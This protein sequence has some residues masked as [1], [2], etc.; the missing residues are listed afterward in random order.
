MTS[1][2]LKMQ[3]PRALA[4]LMFLAVAPLDALKPSDDAKSIAPDSSIRVRVGV[5][6]VAADIADNW[7]SEHR[8]TGELVGILNDGARCEAEVGGNRR[9]RE[10]VEGTSDYILLEKGVCETQGYRR[11][12]NVG[13]VF[14]SQQP[15]TRPLYRCYADGDKSHFAANDAECGHMGE[16][17]ALIGY[18]L[19]E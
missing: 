12:R 18:D 10:Q 4:A 1:S 16:K 11:L 6:L 5:P 3:A 13:Y 19:K 9:V 14:A 17:K 7:F 15:H 2:S 8:Q